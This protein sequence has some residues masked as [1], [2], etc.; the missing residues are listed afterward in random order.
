MPHKILVSVFLTAIFIQLA[1]YLLLFL[2]ARGKSTLINTRKR[3]YPA[4]SVIICARNEAENLKGKLYL[5]LEQN[6]PDYELI[7]VNDGS[8]DDTKDVLEN[9]KLKYSHLRI[10]NINK[11]FKFLRGKKLALTIGLKAAKNDIVLLTDADCHPASQDWIKYM[12][13]NYGKNKSVILGL[14]L[15]KKRKGL[16]NKFIR[17][18]T[19][20]IA[21]QY[22]S[23]TRSGRPYMGVGRNL[24][25]RKELFFNNKGFASHLKLES[26][27]DDLFINEVANSENCIVETNPL[28]F[29]YSE[30]ETKWGDWIRQKKRHLTTS[31][32][33]KK[34]TRR[35]L[36]LEYFSRMILTISFV[37]LLFVLDDKIP[38]LSIYLFLFLIKGLS[39]YIVF[40]S[41]NEKFLF[42]LSLIFEPIMPWIYGLLHISNFIERKRTRW[43]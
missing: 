43:N 37:W 15:Y 34:S 32:M 27:D 23:L 16:L 5:F 19:A 22:I 18:E 10:S 33:Y 41:L 21:M 9:L 38:V 35:I 1:Y 26:G 4:V 2:K 24:S 11:D 3:K 8:D 17:F 13:R 7:V 39:F 28:S 36:G 14:G 12:I 29:T 42:L 30:P 40:K 25:Y 6:Y 20:F 31:E